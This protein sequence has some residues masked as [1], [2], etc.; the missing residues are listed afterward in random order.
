MNAP[1]YEADSLRGILLTELT[2]S[3]GAFRTEAAFTAADA[4]RLLETSRLPC[5]SGFQSI[6]AVLQDLTE[7][8]FLSPVSDVSFRLTEAGIAEGTRC[9]EASTRRRQGI[10]FQPGTQQG[11][12]LLVLYRD[13][14][15]S[16]E[17][18]HESDLAERCWRLLPRKFGMRGKET[19]YPSDNIVRTL[20]LKFPAGYV[21]RVAPLRYRLDPFGVREGRLLLEH[22]EQKR[23]EEKV[24]GEACG[25]E[26]GNGLEEKSIGSA[27]AATAQAG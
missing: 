4:T 20:L 18:L 6:R 22:H 15:N 3:A 5:K 11:T 16:G 23:R 7:G 2:R 13:C 9:T 17:A 21:H 12:V 27:E 25:K 26:A 8:G 14:R 24:H 10:R 1:V 19:L